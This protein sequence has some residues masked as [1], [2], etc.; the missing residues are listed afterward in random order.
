M[1]KNLNSAVRDPSIVFTRKAVFDETL[2]RKSTKICKSIVVIDASQLYPHWVCQ[3]MPV[4]SYTR[5]HLESEKDWFA[6]RQNNTRSF[7]KT[8]TSYFQ[9]TR[10]EFKIESFY[11]TG[12][13]KC[14]RFNVD[15]FYSHCKTVY[16]ASCNKMLQSHLNVGFILIETLQDNHQS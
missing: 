6:P 5:W 3:P 11:T 14:D 13:E 7:E 1:E 2:I 10:T 8:V 16:K 12:R 9:R 15:G 4:G